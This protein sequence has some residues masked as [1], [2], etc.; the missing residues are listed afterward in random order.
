MY[1][2]AIDEQTAY[3]IAEREWSSAAREPTSFAQWAFS[4]PLRS[5]QFAKALHQVAPIISHLIQAQVD[6]MRRIKPVI[7]DVG[8]QCSDPITSIVIPLYG[9]SDFV[10]QQ[11]LCFADDPFIRKW[12]EIIYVIDD[13]RIRADIMENAELYYEL[14]RVP[15][16]IVDGRLN[17]GYSAANNIGASN[18]RALT[19]LFLNS[20][21]FPMQSGW[22]EKLLMALARDTN[23][24]IVGA[25]LNYHNGSIQHDGMAFEWH[26]SLSAHINRHP[27]AG[28]ETPPPRA[29]PQEKMAVTGAC[30][31]MSKETF[32]AVGGFDQN[33]LVGDFE[34][35]DIC[36]KV[37]ALGR[38]I[39]LVEDVS[40]V[41]LERQSFSGVGEPDF[42]QKIVY[43]NLY[44]HEKTW[45]EAIGYS[46]KCDVQ[47]V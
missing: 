44:R 43:Y 1:L 37:R 19:N 25:R 17:R 5:D 10:A 32:E 45:G 7:T 20:D 26:S 13:P 14:Y 47:R 30:M 12:C 29:E 41:H 9:R 38:I 35:S 28:F 6:G 33:Y 40:I 3:V 11:L 31:L 39:T 42:R 46:L 8:I 36:L 21:V 15:F 24:G 18:A 4:F 27:H 23:I 2:V 22:L 16:K 34:D